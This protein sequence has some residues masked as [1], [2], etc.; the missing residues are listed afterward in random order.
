[1]FDA[2]FTSEENA[3]QCIDLGIRDLSLLLHHSM[4]LALRGMIEKGVE[5]KG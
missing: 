2:S 3:E 1:M 5:M 4:H